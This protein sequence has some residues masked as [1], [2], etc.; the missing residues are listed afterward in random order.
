[1]FEAPGQCGTG[2]EQYNDEG[3]RQVN[4]SPPQVPN[5]SLQTLHVTIQRRGLIG[6]EHH[7]APKLLIFLLEYLATNGKFRLLIGQQ[8]KFL[9]RCACGAIACLNACDRDRMNCTADSAWNIPAESLSEYAN[10]RWQVARDVL[11][12]ALP[13]QD[14][15]AFD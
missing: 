2:N 15:D 6:E 12:G 11:E 8:K 3:P 5:F 4:I 14:T 9:V 10:E 1:M 13:K 7:R